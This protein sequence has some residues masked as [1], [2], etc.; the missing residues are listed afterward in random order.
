M[1]DAFKNALDLNK[2]VFIEACAGA[3]KTY[4][5]AKR[6]ARIMDEFAIQGRH[7]ARNILVIT[8]TKKAATEMVSRIYQDLN[9][10]LNDQPIEGMPA[11]FGANLR[12]ADADYKL[13]VR[14]TF[15]QNAI[16]T[17]DS[18]CAG[19]LREH[20]Q[21][22]GLDPEFVPRD[23]VDTDRIFWETWRDF[24][25]R[26][27]RNH[28]PH[29]KALL[30]YFSAWRIQ[31]AVRLI[32]DN[33]QLLGEWLTAA[34]E[35]SDNLHTRLEEYFPPP[36]DVPDWSQQLVNLLALL[37][38]PS[39]MQDVDDRNYQRYSKAKATLKNLNLSIPALSDIAH[40]MDIL[41]DFTTTEKGEW[42]K[43]GGIQA[44]KAKWAKG[45]LR[46]TFVQA[47]KD[48]IADFSSQYEPEIFTRYATLLDIQACEAQHILARF[49]QD[50]ESELQ[51]TLA[52]QKV[53]SFD[54]I[55]TH[56]H[57]LLKDHP[58]IAAEYGRQF[59]HIMVDEFQDTNELRWD[60]IRLIASN[61]GQL[62][63][64]G[65]FIVGDTKQ[66]IYRFNQAD[67]SVMH[68]VQKLIEA[69]GGHR[70]RFNETYRSSQA[71]VDTIINPIMSAH[72]N[73]ES[74]SSPAFD[75]TFQP[76]QIAAASPLKPNQQSISRCVV[77]AI[78]KD[79]ASDP[80]QLGGSPDVIQTANLA[81]EMV[82][83]AKTQ[84]VTDDGK[85]IVGI[86]LRAFTRIGE[87]IRVFNRMDIPF[88]VVA[89]K[90]LFKQ[91]EAFDLFHWVRV[92]INPLD[93]LALAGLLRSPFFALPDRDIHALGKLRAEKNNDT[94]LWACLEELQPTV[95]N[96]LSDW[97]KKLQ[98]E[99][100]DRILEEILN[101]EDRL[102][103][104][105]SETAGS[106]RVANLNRLIHL[107]HQQ[108]LQ[109]KTI[110]AIFHYLDFQINLGGDAAQ[111]DL[112]NPAKI[113]IMTI[114]KAK[115]LE[116]PVV[117][118]PELH[119]RGRSDQSGIAIERWP[120][121]KR[122]GEWLVGLT[123]DNLMAGG[124]KTNLQKFLSEQRKREEEAEDRRL[125]YVAVTRA[126]F[127]LGCLAA[128]DPERF[129]TDHTWWGKYIA[130]HFGL[131]HKQDGVELNELLPEPEVWS[132]Q[133]LNFTNTEIRL[134][135]PNALALPALESTAWNP[136][137][138]DQTPQ[139][140]AEIS[141]HDIMRWV[142]PESDYFVPEV[143]ATAG[144]DGNPYALTFGRVLHKIM[145]M[146]WW[147]S[148]THQNDIRIFLESEGVF[149][150][151]ETYFT[152]LDQTLRQLKSDPFYA[153][154]QN[155]GEDKNFPELPI[156]GWLENES[157]LYRVT[158]IMDLLYQRDDGQWVVLDYK[159]DQ[160]IPDLS[161]DLPHQ[162]WFQIQTYLWI[163][164]QSFGIDAIGELYFM[165]CGERV[166]IEADFDLYVD[167]IAEKQHREPLQ[168]AKLKPDA[169][170]TDL[171]GAIDQR[172]PSGRY[173]LLEPTR[174]LAIRAYQT[175][176]ANQKL[177]PGCIIQSQREFFKRV[178]PPGR[179]LSPDV[180]Q[181]AV[182]DIL[183]KADLSWGVYRQLADAVIQHLKFGTNL[184]APFSDL[185]VLV[186]KWCRKHAVITD[187]DRLPISDWQLPENN[188]PIFVDG[189]FSTTPQDHELLD[190]LQKNY[191]RT[192]FLQGGKDRDIANGWRW[193]N[194]IKSRLPELPPTFPPDVFICFSVEDE[195][196]RAAQQI[197]QLLADGTLADAIKVAVSSMERYVPVIKR[198]FQ[199][200]GIPV[201]IAKHEPVGERPATHLVLSLLNAR[202]SYQL[203]WQ[204]VTAIWLHS[205]LDRVDKIKWDKADLSLSRFD[206]R[207]KLDRF[208]RQQGWSS[209][210]ELRTYAEAEREEKAMRP[211][212][213]RV[214][215]CAE[216]LLKFCEL[217]FQNNSNESMQSA[218]DWLEA[219]I[220]TLQ[221][222]RTV[223]HDEVA[224]RTVFAIKNTLRKIESTWSTYAHRKGTA[225]ELYREL[226]EKLGE[227]EIK[228][229]PQ[230]WGVE[231]LGNQET[232]NLALRHLIV[233]GLSEGQFPV[234]PRKNPYLERLPFNPW[235]FNLALFMRWLRL[236]SDRV[237]FYAPE[238][239]VGGESLQPSTFTEYLNV[240]HDSPWAANQSNSYRYYVS[241]L[242]NRLLSNPTGSQLVRHNA[243]LTAANHAFTG[244]VGA[245][246]ETDFSMS[247]SRL[248]NLLKCPQRYWYSEP[249]RL[250][251]LDE[252]P[253]SG[254]RRRLGNFIHKLL[255]DFGNPEFDGVDGF[256]LLSDDF[257]EAVSYLADLA[258][259][260][261]EDYH[262]DGEL[263]LLT[264]GKLIP[265]LD[266]LRETPDYTLLGRLL[267]WNAPFADQFQQRYFEQPFGISEHENNWSEIEISTP[268]GQ[269]KLHLRGIIDRI[270]TNEQNVW[271]VDYKT[272]KVNIKDTR[273]FFASQLY[274]YLLA[275]QQHF[276]DKSIILSYEKLQSLKNGGHGMSELLGN[277]TS[278]HPVTVDRK[279]RTYDIPVIDNQ[280]S[281]GVLT[282]EQIV[283]QLLDY[284][285]PLKSGSFTLT[286]REENRACAYCE[287]IQI[288][289]KTTVFHRCLPG[290]ENGTAESG[291]SF[292]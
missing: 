73:S 105:F 91:Q 211:D 289:R 46:D 207:L 237:T 48:F 100:L 36:I 172:A 115:G 24:L 178:Y 177:R 198:T 264:T 241:H 25:Q 245:N 126:K 12:Q 167:L 275:L 224:R 285:Q 223:M 193:E 249:L 229:G 236:G 127:A 280:N 74:T 226:S 14:A 290:A 51:Q 130:P 15:S 39:E 141:P 118:L 196:D 37:P 60:I 267:K 214:S 41:N 174:G 206:D 112:P 135:A 75:T 40:L 216:E 108:S 235:Y 146:G 155:L 190:Q 225:G 162:Y 62:R 69:G 201:T 276:P 252:D 282:R 291:A 8:F 169:L 248:D 79:S 179:R 119:R 20:A 184:E 131:P 137:R 202:L 10:L 32:H 148:V 50:F 65:L 270:F 261:R 82:D 99:P 84:G 268:D 271:A 9:L 23:E 124:Q 227:E 233:L 192:Y 200:Y 88:Q 128:I 92:M 199:D 205:L 255:E 260:V 143:M 66:S 113:Q 121:G 221:I 173:Y 222:E 157:C 284:A 44:S 219:A 292:D 188:I 57:R 274:V 272:G 129:P 67:V 256:D 140:F 273:D 138:H 281:D 175:L 144:E 98:A 247:A 210:G 53:L 114:H 111:A 163:V 6:Y 117:I 18:F 253:E 136:P 168:I 30:G 234:T 21:L 251:A 156:L 77:V 97:R 47:V 19:I 78:A 139:Q 181:I 149:L 42:R 34:A 231:I 38:E 242:S 194:R 240:R 86:L 134:E 158:G 28:A 81:R 266:G 186:L 171:V 197:L 55:I 106:Q 52:A 3:G 132:T 89:G 208:V 71:Y 203:S 204:Q 80:L 93:D 258:D 145:E 230:P 122:A 182:A 7:D 164:K 1:T 35:S 63:S 85:P 254:V 159:T 110:H 43:P 228:S 218:A 96:H 238:L 123:L 283:D 209:L 125:F 265:F 269:L 4:V 279:P 239:S 246:T 250:A 152:D 101:G 150:D 13:R 95:V 33:R 94:T 257:D 72:F 262:F 107:I 287:F 288:C 59:K 277:L 165:R 151:Q 133:G 189:L 187:R 232:V 76:T 147:D 153:E 61:S 180:A 278:D 5:L 263:D 103:G 217:F 26:A 49:Y 109:G 170:T 212:W 68:D 45:T 27:S 176:A 116:F 16:S 58:D 220:K 154:L 29:L 22:A 166:G 83:W 31:K 183:K 191:S 56:T 2:N 286:T 185:P 87:Y 120:S 213:Q 54:E 104:W 11:D 259:Q 102:L 244:E 70:L 215:K 160:G 64:Q 161:G 90:G 195:V 142:S 17:I 243:Y